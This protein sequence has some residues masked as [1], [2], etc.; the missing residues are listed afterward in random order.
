MS[1]SLLTT[2]RAILLGA[3]ASA[4]STALADV[5]DLSILRSDEWRV[6]EIDG[7]EVAAGFPVTIAF[8]A[9]GGYS[10]RACN[11]FRG[12]YTA[13]GTSISL[14]HAAATQMAC[15]EPAMS[16]ERGLFEALARVASFELKRNGALWL[17]GAD[18]D[19]LITAYR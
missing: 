8:G 18:G 10:G 2:R 9:D 14:G 16:Q 1:P 17:L 6:T 4:A 15:A 7:E 13:E 11:A 12:S 3:L 19:R 5:D